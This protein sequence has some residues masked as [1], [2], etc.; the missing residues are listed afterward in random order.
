M[1]NTYTH[2]L[3]ISGIKVLLSGICVYISIIY[4]MV[5]WYA[6]ITCLGREHEQLTNKS[7]LKINLTMT[8]S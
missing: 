1:Y 7:K 3:L 2:V 6:V 4:L 5:Y 8:S